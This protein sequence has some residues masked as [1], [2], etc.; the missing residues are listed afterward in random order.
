[1]NQLT[2]A[3]LSPY[4]PHGLQMIFQSK[5]GRIV[6]LEGL[7]HTK[8]FAAT[9]STSGGTMWLNS[10]G[11]K[12][13]LRPLSN[14]TKE[15]NHRGDKFAPVDRM[16]AIASSETERSFVNVLLHLKRYESDD[17]DKTHKDIFSRAPYSMHC[18]ACEHHFD[19]FGLIP[20][21]LAISIH[22]LTE[23]PYEK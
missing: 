3:H 9:V 5:V 20:A 6:A 15:I 2:I 10:S 18:Y 13:L 17:I 14:L 11:F 21:G 4:L 12:P 7:T 22:D 1:M 16:Y 8:G 19:V 23:N